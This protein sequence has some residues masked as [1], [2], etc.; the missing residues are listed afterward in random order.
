MS[1]FPPLAL[2]FH[3]LLVLLQHDLVLRE[4]KSDYIVEDAVLGLGR[5]EEALLLLIFGEDEEAAD[6]LQ[7]VPFTNPQEPVTSLLE[8]LF[9][10]VRKHLL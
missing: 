1:I 3:R 4:V 9:R 5:V 7:E 8:F 6:G 2:L 10:A